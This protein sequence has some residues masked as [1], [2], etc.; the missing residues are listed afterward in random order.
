MNLIATGAQDVR[1][2]VYRLIAENPVFFDKKV[3][4]PLD[5]D[6]DPRL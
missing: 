4:G 6:Y 1:H 5:A 2:Q 3:D